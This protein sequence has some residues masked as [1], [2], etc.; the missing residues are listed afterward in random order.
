[1]TDKSLSVQRNWGKGCVTASRDQNSAVVW[2]ERVTSAQGLLLSKWACMALDWCHSCCCWPVSLVSCPLT[3]VQGRSFGLCQHV[4]RGE[5]LVGKAQMT[6]FTAQ[7]QHQPFLGSWESFPMM[8]RNADDKES[9]EKKQT[10]KQTKNHGPCETHPSVGGRKWP[11]A[12]YSLLGR[13]CTPPLR[14]AAVVNQATSQWDAWLSGS[15]NPLCHREATSGASCSQGR[16]YSNPW[17]LG[18]SKIFQFCLGWFLDPLAPRNPDALCAYWGCSIDSR[19][20]PQVAPH[21]SCSCLLIPG[22]ASKAARLFPYS[23][24]WQQ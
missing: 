16:A 3:G 13:V 24:G 11:Q 4:R 14:E 17:I 23:M 8:Q 12:K 19:W 20:W 1:M 22:S 2:G 9:C 10:N 5:A 18:L 7:G 6:S 15:V 21:L